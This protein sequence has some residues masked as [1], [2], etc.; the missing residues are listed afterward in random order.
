MSES[1]TLQATAMIK[2]LLVIVNAGTN[3]IAYMSLIPKS[4]K[5]ALYF[6]Q[7]RKMLLFYF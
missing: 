4:Q 5:Q 6:V 7:I 1:V 2:P 3:F